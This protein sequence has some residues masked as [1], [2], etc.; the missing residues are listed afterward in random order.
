MPKIVIASLLVFPI[1]VG[2]AQLTTAEIAKTVSPSVVIIQGTTDSGTIIGSGFIISDDGKIVTNLH[3]IRDLKTAGVQLPTGAVFDSVSV[4]ATD[5]RRDLAVV[6]IGGGKL[7]VLEMGNSDSLAV[8]EPLV[9]VGSPRGLEGTVTAGILSS[10]RDMDDGKVLQTDAAI[11]PGNSG[12]PIVNSSG[13]VIGVVSFKLRSAEGLNFAIPIN[14]VRT[15]LSNLHEPMTLDQMR[16]TLT[17]VPEQHTSGASL[18]ETLNWLKLKIPL[19]IVRH[20]YLLQGRK[21]GGGLTVWYT[22]QSVALGLDSC[23][24]VIGFDSTTEVEG[25]QSSA[26]NTVRYTIP[27]GLING[28]FAEKKPTETSNPVVSGDQWEYVLNL[29]ASSAGI[30]D[31]TYVSGLGRSSSRTTD[32]VQLMF[33]EESI[34]QRVLEAFRH[35]GELCRNKE[36]F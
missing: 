7:P 25:V 30:L 24:A 29:T 31:Q 10:V 36:P 3:V 22:T 20:S 23:T 5:E 19:G 1:V 28:G 21:R 14:Y 34:A 33:P 2:Q 18:T 35:A 15:L 17:P 27:L 9:V 4:L 26:T 6:K 16:R 12:G 11:N 13:Q 32:A 8:G